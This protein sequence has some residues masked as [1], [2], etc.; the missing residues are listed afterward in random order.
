MFEGLLNRSYYGN[1]VSQWLTSLAVILA[2]LLV[3]RALYWVTGNV[4]KK[5]T[6]KTKTRLDDLIVD[7]V[8]EPVVLVVTVAGAWI[9]INRLAL[10]VT[11]QHWVDQGMRF[12]VILTITWLVARLLDALCKEYLVPLAENTD[13][14]L[15]DQLLP[16]VRKG[17]KIGLWVLGIVVALNN[18]GYDV[19]ALIAG[20]GIGGLALA[21]AAKDTV[22]NVFGGFTIL[23]DRPFKLN[24]RVKISGFDGF[25]RD[26][27][28]RS[29][30]LETLEGT[31]VTIPN[32]K[33]ADSPVENV[34]LEPSRKVTVNLGLTYNTSLAKMQ[35]AMDTLKSLAAQEA[36]LET[37]VNV[38]FNAF[39]DS[40]MNILFVYF[41]RKDADIL[42]TQTAVN[43]AILDRFSAAGLQF[44]YPTRTLYTK[45]A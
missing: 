40:A 12:V 2:S 32:A 25:I 19:G 17:G 42:A 13:T 30:R 22:S 35:E 1:T 18:V 4:V 9:G 36:R 7:M 14:D 3:G 5:L 26:I 37:K 28:V 45:Q 27:G 29:T 6:A 38:A 15:D 11:V 23:A 41:I 8:E 24:D 20:L 31:V 34:S 43:M 33:F 10:S 21:M 44:A 39:G 16:I